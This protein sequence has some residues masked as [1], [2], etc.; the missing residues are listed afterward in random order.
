MIRDV[1]FLK[2]HLLCDLARRLDAALP[3]ASAARVRW[4]LS[5]PTRLLSTILVGN[6]ISGTMRLAECLIWAGALAGGFMVALSIVERI[7]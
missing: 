2:P 6:T 5:K 7:F 4:L 1:R 3:P